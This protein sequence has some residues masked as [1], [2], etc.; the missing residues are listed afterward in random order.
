[1]KN[2]G[3]TIVLFIWLFLISNLL[4]WYYIYK[5]PNVLLYLNNLELLTSLVLITII[6]FVISIVYFLYYNKDLL[7]SFFNIKFEIKKII[8]SSLLFIFWIFFIQFLSK[9]FPNQDNY[10]IM[11][12]M[13]KIKTFDFFF[14]LLVFVVL[15]AIYEEIIFRFILWNFF[16][17]YIKS[18]FIVIILTA[19]LFA[20]M[21]LQYNMNLIIEVFILGIIL[22]IIKL[23]YGLRYS[24]L[25]HILNNSLIVTFNCLP[26]LLYIDNWQLKNIYQEYLKEK[27]FIID[28]MCVKW[29]NKN[30]FLISYIL[31]D[32]TFKTCYTNPNKNN[33]ICIKY[34]KN[35][36]NK[37][38]KY[39]MLYFLD[40]KEK[41]YVNNFIKSLDSYIEIYEKQIKYNNNNKFNN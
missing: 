12:S 7:K 35:I 28:Y 26:A 14:Y 31:K 10:N 18:N 11:D 4:S 22:G 2:L 20:I 13:L 5:N 33:K 40:E 15:A 3:K 1:M 36:R 38:Q 27:N 6:P 23:L 8:F 32:Q 25:L 9:F 39:Q 29:N 34:I 17:N 19:F 41:K 24:I 37:F 30:P 16:K 21:H